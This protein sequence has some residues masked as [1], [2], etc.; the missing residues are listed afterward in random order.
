M[1]NRH[2][3]SKK[4]IFTKVNFYLKYSGDEMF[5]VMA[6]ADKLDEFYNHGAIDFLRSAN[7]AG[8]IC[9][10]LLIASYPSAMMLF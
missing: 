4:I 9:T 1:Q 6:V 7:V 3:F 8:N 10:M 2:E 5:E